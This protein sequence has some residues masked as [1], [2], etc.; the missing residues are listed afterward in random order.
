[1]TGHAAPNRLG[2]WVFR[3][4]LQPSSQAAGWCAPQAVGE[5]DAM[6]YLTNMAPRLLELSRVLKPTGSIHLH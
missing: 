3:L 2:G 1:V 5:N 4:A 6:A